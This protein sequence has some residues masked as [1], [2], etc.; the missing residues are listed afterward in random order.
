MSK[1]R[2]RVSFNL[3][4]EILELVK[5]AAAALNEDMSTIVNEALKFRL[6]YI[7]KEKHATEAVKPHR[8][9]RSNKDLTFEELKEIRERMNLLGYPNL[10]DDVL[11]I[12]RNIKTENGMKLAWRKYNGTEKW[13]EYSYDEMMDNNGNTPSKYMGEKKCQY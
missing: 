1:Q 8:T 2:I 9:I 4:P 13:K 12:Y 6:E 7:T 11:W 10:H 5:I 3:K